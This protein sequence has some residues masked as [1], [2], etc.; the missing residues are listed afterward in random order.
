MKQLHT[1]SNLDKEV[2]KVHLMDGRMRDL[3]TSVKSIK[4]SIQGLNRAIATISG[5]LDSIGPDP[6]KNFLEQLNQALSVINAKVE[7][8]KK[9]PE[10]LPEENV[11]HITGLEKTNISSPNLP[12]IR[13]VWKGETLEMTPSMLKKAKGDLNKVAQILAKKNN[14]RVVPMAIEKEEEKLAGSADMEPEENPSKRP[15]NSKKEKARIKKKFVFNGIKTWKSTSNRMEGG[16]VNPTTMC[17]PWFPMPANWSSFPAPAAFLQD[18][19]R[20]GKIKGIR[21]S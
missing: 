8:V 16:L 10:N 5:R 14:K 17:L 15:E 21:K 2:E 4:D 6:T 13:C 7:E 9:L 20:K 3:E 19:R 18:K 1:S 11:S 12:V